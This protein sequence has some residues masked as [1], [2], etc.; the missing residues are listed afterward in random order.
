MPMTI[1]L[2]W[3]TLK[4][5]WNEIFAAFF[6]VLLKGTA[7]MMKNDVYSLYVSHSQVVAL[8][9][10]WIVTSQEGLEIMAII[11]KSDILVSI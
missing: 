5:L 11:R 3:E 2:T 1:Q 7:Q 4:C 8:W 6:I 10:F 9:K